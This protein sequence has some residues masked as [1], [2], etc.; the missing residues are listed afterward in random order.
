[1]LLPG[2]KVGYYDTVPIGGFRVTGHHPASDTE[3]AIWHAANTY[4][5]PFVAHLDAL[6][7]SLYTATTDRTEWVKITNR[8][9][10]EAKRIGAGKPIRPFIWPQYHDVMRSPLSGAYID[11]DYWLLQLSTIRDAGADGIVFWGGHNTRWDDTQAWWRAT[12][13]FLDEH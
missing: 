2:L 12:L 3:L 8:I 6:Y 4:L 7:P 5:I 1:M 13:D 10:S 9:L 11:Y